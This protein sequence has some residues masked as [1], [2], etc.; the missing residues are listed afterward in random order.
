LWALASNSQL[1]TNLAHQVEI[2]EKANRVTQSLKVILFFNAAEEKKVWEILDR[3]K[4]DPGAGVIL[5]DA[6]RDNKPSASNASGDQPPRP[7]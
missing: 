6:R 4:I 1:E 2:Y 7:A 5:I 3:L